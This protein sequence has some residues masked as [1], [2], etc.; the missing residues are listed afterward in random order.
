M[1]LLALGPPT[2]WLLDRNNGSTSLGICEMSGQSKLSGPPALVVYDGECIFCRNFARLL[3]LRESVG[4]V[5]LLDARAADW[6][7]L[8]YQHQ[9][10]DLH[11][12]MLFVWRGRV[13]HAAAAMQML[14]ALTSRVSWF[15]RFAAAVFSH[16]AAARL[17][18]PVLNGGRMLLLA[19][20]G[21]G[22]IKPPPA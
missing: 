7:V 8:A 16:P 18:Y 4:P 17:F 2:K 5:E 13:Y 1:G 9:G 14:A 15:N 22:L 19:L 3:R 10:Y 12:G 21:K 6:R 20:S 11:Q